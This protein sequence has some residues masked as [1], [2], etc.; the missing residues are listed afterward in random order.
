MGTG[1]R[2]AFCALI[3]A[4]ILGLAGSRYATSGVIG[5]DQQL[6]QSFAG[7]TVN[8]AQF[9]EPQSPAVDS[10]DESAKARL[11]RNMLQSP[12][13]F[14][15]NQGQSD[16]RVKFLS[17]GSGYT[18]FLT[19]SEA[20]L[21]LNPA[22]ARLAKG[23]SAP[24]GFGSN[25]ANPLAVGYLDRTPRPGNAVPVP[26]GREDVLRM[27]LVGA[28]SQS[29]ISG[30]DET[31]AKSNYFIG[32]DL[33]KWRTNV[34]N[35]AKVEYASVYPGIDLVYYGNQRQLEYDFVVAPGADPREITLGFGQVNGTNNFV[36]VKIDANGDLIVHLTAGDVSFHKPLVY[37]NIA[38]GRKQT[39]KPVD[40]R[41]TLKADGQV[42]FAVGAYDR[43]RRL[44]I[45]PIVSFS[46]YIGGSNEDLATGI[47]I[48][49]FEDVVIA[50]STR[51]VDFPVAGAIESYHPGTCG[52]LPCRDVFVSKFNP[53]ATNLQYST[54][55]GGANDDVASNLVLDKAGDIFVVGYTLST[56]FPVTPHATQKTFGGG[57][58][59]GDAFAFELAS[60]GG[61]AYSTYIG[62]SGDD[63]AYGVTVD[64]IPSATPNLY[65]VGYTT[66]K[67][68]PTTT[69]AYQTACG[70]SKAD[71][72]ENGFA[73]KLAPQ[74]TGIVF[75]TYLGGSGGLGDAAYGVVVDSNDNLYIAGITGSPNFP[76]TTGAYSRKCGS[77]GQCNGTYDGFVTEM[78]TGGNGLVFSTF[79]G[80]NDYDY[81]AGIAL[82]S[83][84]AIYVSGNTISTDFPTTAGAAQPT[85]GGTSAGCVPTTGAIC[86]DVTVTKL[87]AGGS[88]LA[89]STYL[90]GTLDEYPGMSMAV[91][92]SGNA[93]VTGQ[94]SSL[95]FPQVNPFQ[96]GYGGGS[97]DAFL[98]VV[99]STGTA[100]MASSYFGGNGQDFGYRTILDPNANVF[101]S[102]GTLSTNLFVTQGAFQTICGTDGTCN[103]GLMDA[104]TAKMIQSADVSISNQAAPNPVKSG[105]DLTYQIKVRNNG[106]DTGMAITTT[107]TVPAGTT[108]V[109]VVPTDGSCTSPPVGGTGTVTC[110]A[111][112]LANGSKINITMV[113]H[114]T[115]ASGSKISD[116]ASVSSTTYDPKKGNNSITI[117]VSVD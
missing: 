88:T 60:K 37:Q 81:V 101:V 61:I 86:G 2:V 44:V 7:G 62:G 8:N 114:V 3:T 22:N 65:V 6:L 67:N 94:T 30:V 79:L 59:T 115:A 12:M 9:A 64:Y 40:G 50:G 14:E 97:S 92:A 1:T 24:S 106:P 21:A 66:S 35:F 43:S 87:N 84:G 72:C 91:D 27:R 15:E 82:D 26:V 42:G 90:G 28:N 103:G 25:P 89:Y 96:H 63:Q 110:T 116:K 36:P 45:D 33:S 113:V 112:S 85:F 58:V 78:N 95:N 104:W 46:T 19:S 77:D 109:S 69:G 73:T 107:D 98:T 31:P 10:V 55:I 54:Y 108:F 52:G 70:L 34:S 4:G 29:R 20:V 68:F 18:L 76:T 57:T 13:N 111:S 100:F 39:K 75:S 48:D 17:R 38:K 53:T 16:K 56:D 71:T 80:G 23:Q 99:N 117:S 74:D 11:V 47:G 93:Y 32:K 102:G 105:S 49:K 83:A 51:S 41:Y 5:V